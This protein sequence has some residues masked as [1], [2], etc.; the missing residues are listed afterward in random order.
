MVR[1]SD[2]RMSGT[3]FGSIVLHVTPEAAAGGPLALVRNGDQIELS[4]DKR[5]INLLG[6]RSRT[7]TPPVRV[8]AAAHSSRPY[9]RLYVQHVEQASSGMDFDFLRP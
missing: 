2:A 4:V 8:H 1:I 7:R 9:Q 6:R 5:E 3:A